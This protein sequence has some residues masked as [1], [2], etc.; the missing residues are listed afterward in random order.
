MSSR[1]KRAKQQPKRHLVPFA[2]IL[3]VSI[4]VGL[5]GFSAVGAFALVQSW[6][7]DVPSLEGVDAFNVS[8]KT[9]VYAADGVT[10]IGSFFM[11][12][13]EP[14]TAEQVSPNV[15]DAT[16][17]V[18]DERF[19]GHH[20]VDYYGIARAAVNDFMGGDLQGASTITQ[21]LVRQTVLTEEANETTIRRKVREVHLA[22]ELEKKY[23]KQ[24][25]L[26][27]Y[28]NTI[29][30]GDGAYGIQS[31]AQHYFSKNASELTVSE[32]ALL[33]GIPQSP[34]HNNPVVYP[35]NALKRRN[36]VLDRMYVNGYIGTEQELAA[37]KATELNLNVRDTTLDGIYQQPYFTSFVRDE[38]FKKFPKDQILKDGLTVYTSIDLAM[39]AYAEETC[40]AKEAN[41]PE[42]VEVSLVCVEPG[43]GYIKAMRGGTDFYA[44]QFNTATQMMRQGGSTFK[45]FALVTAIEQG[46]SPQTLV[47]G[48]S[49]VSI[50]MGD[51]SPPWPVS[52]YG[53]ASMGTMSLAQATWSSSNTAYARV[54]R[55]LGAKPVQDTAIRMGVGSLDPEKA[56]N[57]DQKKLLEQIGPSVV[58][59]GYGVNTLEMASS[60]SAL[61]TGGVLHE[62]TAIV[63]VVDHEGNV[64]YDHTNEAEGNRVLAPEV[65]YAANQVLKGVVSGGTGTSANLGWQVAAGKTGTADNYTDSWFVGYTPQL[66]TAVWIGMRDKM[67]YIP[68]NVGGSNCCPV[69]REFMSN[70]L[71]GAEAQ[72]F[73][74][75]NNPAYNAKATFLSAEEQKKLEEEEAKKKA[76][77]E[78]AKKAEE[79]A[80]KKAEA[81]ARK[82]ARE[83]A[84]KKAEKEAE[85]PPASEGGSG[86]GSGGASSGGAAGSGSGSGGASSSGG[87]SGGASDD[88]GSGGS[89]AGSGGSGGAGS[90]AGDGSARAG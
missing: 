78:A 88:D 31:A 87:S 18:E 56:D 86:S 70:A 58:L 74:S 71:Q 68:D 37:L 25:V 81:D 27:M 12:D 52:N 43:T 1:K 42:G 4:A 66:S 69:W 77:E 15:F 33:C 51:G 90:G 22:T 54:V 67:E 80:A 73:P 79:D 89:G 23:S 83:D 39:S 62:P 13:R 9:R 16:V 10:E 34:T 75:A 64:I 50:D 3:I 84:R 24:E 63:K 29:N 5:V 21:Q 2:L 41:L 85:T 53:G 17:A 20:G 46:Y 38:L 11:F 60:F 26:M 55:K 36:V 61:A 76:D 82:K 14:V 40:A 47:S 30:Y 49:P 57:P 48:A 35:D 8:H 28:L 6:L 65:A 32:A 19:W 7:E 72:D 44:D 45:V 59:G